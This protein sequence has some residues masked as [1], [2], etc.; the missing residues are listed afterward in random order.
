M[1]GQK[2]KKT[3][4]RAKKAKKVQ[5]KESIAVEIAA[6]RPAKRLYTLQD[7]AEY[8]GRP[9]WGIRVLIWNKEMPYVKGKHS[10]KLYIDVFDLDDYIKKHKEGKPEE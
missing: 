1:K 9:V 6:P 4:K 5:S 3:R 2:E 8:M 7:S 10:R